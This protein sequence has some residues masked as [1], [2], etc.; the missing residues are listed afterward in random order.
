MEPE[1]NHALN[2]TSPSKPAN[3]KDNFH[4]FIFDVDK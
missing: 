3:E 2:E 4:N 1:Y